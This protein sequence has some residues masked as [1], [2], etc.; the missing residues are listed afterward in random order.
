MP[1]SVNTIKQ[2]LELISPITKRFKALLEEGFL[3]RVFSTTDPRYDAV[4]KEQAMKE[5]NQLVAECLLLLDYFKLKN[6]HLSEQP[7]ADEHLPKQ[8]SDHIE[9]YEKVLTKLKTIKQRIPEMDT[10]VHVAVLQEPKDIK[11]NKEPRFATAKKTLNTP[12]SYE[13]HYKDSKKTDFKGS[14]TILCKEYAHKNPE[15][16]TYKRAQMIHATA[17][18]FPTNAEKAKAPNV[19][20]MEYAMT[21]AMNV[22]FHL[23]D[24]PTPERPIIISGKNPEEL[25]F[26]WT[27][28]A[29]LGDNST[30]M[31]FNTKCLSVIAPTYD[32]THMEFEPSKE[33]GWVS[34]FNNKSCYASCFKD[35]PIAEKHKEQF[36]AACS[37]TFGEDD[38]RAV[39]ETSR[40]FQD[41]LKKDLGFITKG[42]G[43]ANPPPK[44]PQKI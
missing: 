37:K 1:E 31:R 18:S 43:S 21:F 30:H 5:M 44:P 19:A 16:G 40:V 35:N 41:K 15:D 20:K 10:T 24:P 25:K 17:N 6:K 9:F 38:K 27:A 4:K 42:D 3:D 11:V 8:I 7:Q 29:Y 23:T 13:Y 2:E 12:V 36:V 26:I 39:R 22:L 33:L 32:G 28:F 34:G 14:S